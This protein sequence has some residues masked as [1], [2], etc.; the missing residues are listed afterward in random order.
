MLPK[1]NGGLKENRSE[2]ACWVL[3]DYT[4]RDQVAVS[5]PATHMFQ[6]F[7][8]IFWLRCLVYPPLAVRC[9]VSLKNGI[10]HTNH[11][12]CWICSV[13]L[14]PHLVWGSSHSP[15]RVKTKNHLPKTNSSRLKNSAWKTMYVVSFGDCLLLEPLLLV[16]ERVRPCLVIFG[17]PRILSHANLKEH[18]EIRGN[19]LQGTNISHLGKRKIIFKSAVKSGYDMLLPRR[20]SRIGGLTNH[21]WIVNHTCNSSVCPCITCTCFEIG[22]IFQDVCIYS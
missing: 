19:T 8:R 21:A 20:V 12:W 18:Q 13:V 7:V 1:S 4:N 6:R 3:G 22:Y 9:H 16:S 2:S 10:S 5:V 14:L 17:W 15:F 11:C